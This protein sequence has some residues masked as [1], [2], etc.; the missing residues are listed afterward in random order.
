MKHLFCVILITFFPYFELSHA[1]AET[2]DGTIEIEFTRLVV[3]SLIELNRDELTQSIINTKSYDEEA[4]LKRISDINAYGSNIKVEGTLVKWHIDSENE[5][6]G[7]RF[8]LVDRQGAAIRVY[9][10]TLGVNHTHNHIS[11]GYMQVEGKAVLIE[12][13]SDEVSSS[14]PYN[15]TNIEL[16]ISDLN[17]VPVSAASVYTEEPMIRSSVGEQRTLL[18]LYQ[19]TNNSFPSGYTSATAKSVFIANVD[20]YVRVTS[21]GKAWTK[22]DAYGPY[23][24]PNA[25][26][27]ISHLEPIVD[28]SIYDRI[29]A[30]RGDS[31]SSGIAGISSVGKGNNCSISTGNCYNSSFSIIYGTHN[32]SGRIGVHEFIHG[33][34]NTHALYSG[35]PDDPYDVMSYATRGGGKG[36]LSPIFTENLGWFNETNIQT[37]TPNNMGVYSLGA[38]DISTNSLQVLKI[39]TPVLYPTN[40]IDQNGQTLNHF[41]RT[42]YIS[43]RLPS[44]T[45]CFEALDLENECIGAMVHWNRPGPYVF[46]GNSYNGLAY[47]Q[48]ILKLSGISTR[49]SLLPSKT[50][51]DNEADL[52]ITTLGYNNGRLEVKIGPPNCGDGI[53][54][55]NEG[56]QCEPTTELNTPCS[57]LGFEKGAVTCSNACKLDFSGCQRKICGSNDLFLGDR[58]C[59]TTIK[60]DRT[61]GA[62]FT[63]CGKNNASEGFSACNSQNEWEEVRNKSEGFLINSSPSNNFRILSNKTFNQFQSEPLYY[64]T[65]LLFPFDTSAIPDYAELISANMSL[66]VSRSSLF[67]NTHANSNDFL[68]LVTSNLDG[69]NF[70]NLKTTDY[71]ELTQIEASHR[72]DISDSYQHDESVANEIKFTLNESGLDFINKQGFS[73]LGLKSGYDFFDASPNND[74]ATDINMTFFMSDHQTYPP[75]LTLK[76]FVPKFS[77]IRNNGSKSV[78]GDLALKTQKEVNGNWQDQRVMFHSAI[79]IPPKTTLPLSA[80]WDESW[81]PVEIGKYRA[82]VTYS[83]NG[84]STSDEHVFFVK[85]ETCGDGIKNGNDICDGNDFGPY[86]DGIDKCNVFDGQFVFG[87][88]SCSLACNEILLEGCVPQSNIDCRDPSHTKTADGTCIGT[89]QALPSDGVLNLASTASWSDMISAT[90]ADSVSNNSSILEGENFFLRTSSPKQIKRPVIIFDTSSLAGAYIRNAKLK[91]TTSAR[92]ALG[93]VCPSADYMTVVNVDVPLAPLLTIEDFG[94]FKD[95]VIASNQRFN[96]SSS[97]TINQS[98]NFDLVNDD[99]VNRFS[100]INKSGYTAFGLQFGIDRGVPIPSN[101]LCAERKAAF[102]SQDELQVNRRPVLEVEYMP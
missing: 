68:S 89:I 96:V 26:S 52:T 23:T 30:V 87:N 11:S 84:E 35:H 53:I 63:A 54:Q 25:S 22:V 99:L 32:L 98:R 19:L 48:E 66:F 7:D 80:Y 46:D 65:R 20:S 13:S 33:L 47:E 24:L 61:D 58:T 49:Y 102:Y 59:E 34:G 82:L 27:I 51:F 91:L 17:E 70:N 86:G 43:H 79:Q 100:Y 6:H 94:N 37:I 74:Q 28:L 1:Y 69:Y 92:T 81:N 41:N 83:S 71:S 57:S 38:L 36:R 50:F 12:G 72:F 60:S 77:I 39:V 73:I 44:S 2:Q 85:E 29:V 8:Y 55:E 9:Q 75:T 95:E 67:T 62:L 31:S 93:G 90:T 14:L 40:V 15:N 45:V 78:V 76:Y 42:Y 88:L 101:W 18:V 16:A 10:E 4:K 5:G 56:E 97:W 64:I 3:P 21:Y